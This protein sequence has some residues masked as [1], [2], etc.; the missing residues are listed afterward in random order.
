M[1]AIVLL[2]LII[3]TVCTHAK[4][5]VVLISTSRNWVNYRHSENVHRFYTLLHHS[6]SHE[7]QIIT[8]LAHEYQLDPRNS[9]SKKALFS[10]LVPTFSQLDVSINTI[11][12]VLTQQSHLISPVLTS[13]NNSNV[14]LYITGHGATNHLKIHN[15]ALLSSHKLYNIVSRMKF[16]KLLIVLDTCAGASMFL[17]FP[18]SLS[19]VVAISSSDYE[20]DSYSTDFDLKLGVFTVDRFTKGL[21]DVLSRNRYSSVFDLGRVL[22]KTKI[23]STVTINRFSVEGD[24]IWSDFIG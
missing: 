18:S 17:A 5:H 24:W 8:F 2:I 4:N 22:T 13:T 10:D 23:G 1:L 21:V 12:S 14:L 3:L 7:N 20:E 9:R 19:N 16:G 15:Q 11:E 6:K